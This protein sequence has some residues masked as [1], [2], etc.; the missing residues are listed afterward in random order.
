[1]AHFKFTIRKLNNL[2]SLKENVFQKIIFS[3][4]AMITYLEILK[5]NS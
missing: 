4:M 3:D 5:V 1:M 2:P